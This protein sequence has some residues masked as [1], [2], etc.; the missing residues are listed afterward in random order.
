MY[1]HPQNTTVSD[2]I[3]SVEGTHPYHQRAE[4][5]KEEKEVSKSSKCLQFI[6]AQA[7]ACKVFLQRVSNQ[8]CSP[9]QCVTN[10]YHN[11]LNSD[12]TTKHIGPVWNPDFLEVVTT[13]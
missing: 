9:I 4:E 2:R 10:M 13:R 3:Y 12:K 11:S 6:S 8:D 5:E 7:S 1:V